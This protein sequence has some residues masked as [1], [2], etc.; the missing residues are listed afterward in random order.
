[1]TDNGARH[2]VDRG[3][4]ATQIG[5]LGVRRDDVLVVHCAFRTV[6]PV[7]GGPDGLIDGLLDALGPGGTLVMPS[8]AG[9]D[10]EP[11]DPRSSPVS[12]DLGIVA[13]TFQRRPGVERAGHPFAFAALGPQATR[14]LADPLPL[15]PHIPESPIGRVHGLDGK[16]L[17]LG[18]GHGEN[19]T[20]HLAELLAGVPY[21][22][23]K[24]VT[25]REG[26]E[27]RRVAYGENDHCCE[28][29]V[30]ADGWLSG[31]GLQAEGPVGHAHARLMRSRDVVAVARERL[32]A[33]PLL[34]LHPAGAGCAE[35]EAARA[36][37]G[38][39]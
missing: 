8:W 32:A 28:R 15:P 22:V 5:A 11:F 2:S 14:I 1:M 18:V 17:L 20:L 16:V 23:P 6:R 9:L 7:D 37:I 30:L 35:C 31:R 26:T 27:T 36:S 3:T 12:P 4:L 10:D 29:F 39:S 24:H 21:R 19:T 25:V 38:V 33:D 34:F 13:E